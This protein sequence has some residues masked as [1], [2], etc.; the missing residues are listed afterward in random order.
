MYL[1]ASSC[2]SIVISLV[3]CKLNLFIY[4]NFAFAI[5]LSTYCLVAASHLATKGYV[6]EYVTNNQDI[7][8]TLLATITQSNVKVPINI[9]TNYYAILVKLINVNLTPNST[10][11]L[12]LSSSEIKLVGSMSGSVNASLMLNVVC[13][14]DGELSILAVN[15]HMGVVYMQIGLGQTEAEIEYLASGT[16]EIY[17][18]SI[19]VD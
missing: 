13:I 14:E 18:L 10:M 11:R 4:F 6:D 2:E 17:G 19:E 12:Y 8:H 1:S 3:P 16:V 5:L 15:P 9:S 7:K